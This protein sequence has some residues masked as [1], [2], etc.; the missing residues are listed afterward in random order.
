M[1]AK[2]ADLVRASLAKSDNIEVPCGLGCGN[3]TREWMQVS[4][5]G[6]SVTMEPVK[7]ASHEEVNSPSLDLRV[8]H[9]CFGVF[10]YDMTLAQKA[11]MEFAA[12]RA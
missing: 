10:I 8:C 9:Q 5:I 11:L 12:R 2:L 7:G 6:A 1:A 3:L 4:V